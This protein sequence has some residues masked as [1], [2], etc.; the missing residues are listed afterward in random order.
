MKLDIQRPGSETASAL[1][2]EA[3]LKFLPS[4]GKRA[5][6]EGK[7]YTNAILHQLELANDAVT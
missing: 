1:T 4:G 3:V 5:R 7:L 6:V 2:S